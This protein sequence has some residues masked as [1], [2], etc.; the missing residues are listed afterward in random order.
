MPE[1][2]LIAGHFLALKETSKALPPNTTFHT[3]IAQLS[4]RFPTGIFYINLWPFSR[5][6]MV[7]TTPSAASQVQ[8]F[9]LGKPPILCRPLDTLTGGPSLIT[10]QGTTWKKWRSLFNPGFSVGYMIGLAPAITDEVAVFCGLLRERV[11]QGEVFQLEDL[12]LR[13]TMDTIGAVAL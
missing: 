1:F 3:V 7:V 9:N 4:K 11:S 6:L 13:L 12:T 2:R 5:T 10:M 8:G